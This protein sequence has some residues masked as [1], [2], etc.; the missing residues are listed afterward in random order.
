V[1]VNCTSIGMHPE[2]DQSPL[3]RSALRPGMV[4]FDT[5]YNP[6]ETRLLADARAAGCQVISGLSM[7]VRQAAC[8]YR[9]W[10]DS[11]PDTDRATACVT[12][13]L[14]ARHTRQNPG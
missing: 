14:T 9:L 3:A 5:I 8:Q 4:V 13:A 2:A 11:E 7:F 1:V 6:L 10:T 12:K